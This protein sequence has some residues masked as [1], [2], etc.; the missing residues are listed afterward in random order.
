M[1]FIFAGYIFFCIQ[2][3]RFITLIS[4]KLYIL[5]VAILVSSF[6]NFFIL[7]DYYTYFEMYEHSPILIDLLVDPFAT[8][9][10]MGVEPGYIILNSIFKYLSLSY[11]VLRFFILFFV[12]YTKLYLIS[13]ISNNFMVS[14]TAYLAFILF[15]DMFILRQAIASTLIAIGV[16][17]IYQGKL[18]KASFFLLIAALFHVIALISWPML[19]IYKYQFKRYIYILLVLLAMIIGYFGLGAIVSNL[20]VS[21]FGD[22][23]FISDKLIRYSSGERNEATGVFRF[24]TLL[25]L[26]ILLFTIACM[27]LR[28]L[29]EQ[30][31][32]ILNLTLYAFLI[33]VLFNDFGILGDRGYRVISFPFIVFFG[34]LT[35]LFKK[36]DRLVISFA[37]VLFFL[38]VSFVFINSDYIKWAGIF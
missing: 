17:Y 28:K 12:V 26:A 18:T 21:I 5:I 1:N 36:K 8:F 11:G 34:Y 27:P 23:S 14:V 3:G 30:Y 32:V 37:F 4:E 35:S 7:P 22:S 25:T 29:T 15:M 13:K 24:S 10:L 6:A 38:A 31:F 9:V 20:I 2:V 33:L 19:L 16:F